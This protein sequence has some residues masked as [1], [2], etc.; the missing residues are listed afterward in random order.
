M[1]LGDIFLI[2]MICLVMVFSLL[3]V[4][5]ELWDLFGTPIEKLYRMIRNWKKPEDS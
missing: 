4:L 2:S 5:V 1:T 3:I